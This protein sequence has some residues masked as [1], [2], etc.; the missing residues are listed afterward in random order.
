MRRMFNNDPF[1]SLAIQAQLQ[2]VKLTRMQG[3]LQP[4]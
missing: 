1:S 3:I 2:Q 4:K